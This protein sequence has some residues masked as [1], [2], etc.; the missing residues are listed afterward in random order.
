MTIR[1]VHLIEWPSRHDR[2]RAKRPAEN[3]DTGQPIY[4]PEEGV[5]VALTM[6][7]WTG[8][9]PEPRSDGW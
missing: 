4:R 6:G 3:E 8:C 2:R 7:P 5:V 1:K 9:R